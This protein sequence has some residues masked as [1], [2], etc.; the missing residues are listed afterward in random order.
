MFLAVGTL[1]CTPNIR[2]VGRGFEGGAVEGQREV[3]D[4]ERAGEIEPEMAIKINVALAEIESN[5]HNLSLFVNF[6]SLPRAEKRRTVLEQ[7]KLF[8]ASATR[9]D[10]AGVLGLKSAKARKRVEDFKRNFRRGLG[11]LR[12]IEASIPVEEVTPSASPSP[13]PS[14]GQLVGIP[15]KGRSVGFGVIPLSTIPPAE[16]PSASKTTSPA[17][18]F[19]LIRGRKQA[20]PLKY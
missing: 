16:Q 8:Q 5:G 9:L 20:L 11:V 15:I 13:A 2:A 6:E 1:A 18:S 14:P 12:I 7:I 3:R 17:P 19:H 10:N 4:M